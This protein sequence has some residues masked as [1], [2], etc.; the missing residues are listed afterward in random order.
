MWNRFL[1]KRRSRV[2]PL[3]TKQVTLVMP[4]WAYHFIMETLYL[5]AESSS[6]ELSLRDEL[7]KALDTIEVQ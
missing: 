4:E 5:D 1:P 6:W 3:M 7:K 2:I